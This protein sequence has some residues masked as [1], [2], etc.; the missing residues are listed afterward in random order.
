M[1][2]KMSYVNINGEA[3]RSISSRIL[4]EISKT[5]PPVEFPRE[6]VTCRRVKEYFGRQRRAETFVI[7]PGKCKPML[8]KIPKLSLSERGS[9]GMFGQ[10][11][12][13]RAVSLM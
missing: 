1:E 4:L 9:G 7:F 6:V 12:S 8:V 10:V 5:S 2:P 13:T 11:K 3:P